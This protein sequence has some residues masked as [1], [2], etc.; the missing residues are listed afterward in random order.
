MNKM[1]KIFDFLIIQ[2]INST[3]QKGIRKLIF[4]TEKNHKI[5]IWIFAKLKKNENLF[6]LL[7]KKNR[8]INP[9]IYI[10]LQ[11]T[12]KRRDKQRT[13]NL[14]FYP[15]RSR[16]ENCRVGR[17][18]PSWRRNP[19]EPKTPKIRR[20]SPDNRLVETFATKRRTP[21][22]TGTQARPLTSCRRREDLYMPECGL[23][24]LPA[25]PISRRRDRTLR[26]WLD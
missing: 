11:N 17:R 7:I 15:R 4:Y 14:P 10:I 5:K 12:R 24:N 16:E 18:A 23:C 6:L 13:A 3:S 19:A 25:V 22:P 9:K 1:L 2:S 21:P 26:K 20:W 8:I